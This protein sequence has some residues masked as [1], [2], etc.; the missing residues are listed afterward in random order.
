MEFYRDNCYISPL[1]LLITYLSAAGG[2]SSRDDLH[3]DIY[4]AVQVLKQMTFNT[5]RFKIQDSRKQE[6]QKII[7]AILAEISFLKSRLLLE[8]DKKKLAYRFT[9]LIRETWNKDNMVEF[10]RLINKSELT[11]ILL[12]SCEKIIR[13]R[14]S[15]GTINIE[16]QQEVAIPSR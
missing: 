16:E 4:N 8:F 14:E 5:S 9:E 3:E 13:S 6:K 1:H 10:F 7:P 11:E 12:D 15:P 2:E